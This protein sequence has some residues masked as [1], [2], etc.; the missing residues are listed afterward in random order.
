MKRS[1]HSSKRVLEE[2]RLNGRRYQVL[3]RLG[4]DQRPRLRVRQPQPGGALERMIL[5]LPKD[6]VA[7]A[8]L[9]T[10]KR[11]SQGTSCLPEIIDCATKAGQVYLVTKWIDGIN[12]EKYIERAMEGKTIWPSPTEVFYRY[13]ELAHT[14]SQMYQFGKLVHGDLKPGNL[15]YTTRP[16]RWIPVD[17]GSAWA[18]KNSAK[19]E[20]GDGLTAGYASPE[21]LT[22]SRTPGFAS[23]QFSATVVLYEMLTGEL[24]Y[25]GIGGAAALEENRE[26]FG[27]SLLP[28]S[29]KAKEKRFLP[30]RVWNAIDQV[31]VT[32]LVLDPSSRFKSASLWREAVNRARRSFDLEYTE[33]RERGLMD[34]A[35]DRV[36]GWLARSKDGE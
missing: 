9:D 14:L 24:P 10:L 36:I 20:Q 27:D 31:A 28:P 4:S 19:R 15:I 25:G 35:I 34:Q 18:I 26:A 23:D 2:L 22:G 21:Q 1:K 30:P 13:A 16:S 29:Q 17:F 3:E 32:A 11:I 33:P 7:W 8:H 5:V 6:R 12:L